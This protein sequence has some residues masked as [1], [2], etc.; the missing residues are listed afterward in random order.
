MLCALCFVDDSDVALWRF[1]CAWYVAGGQ[2]WAGVSVDEGFF[3]EGLVNYWL[4]VGGVH[5]AAGPLLWAMVLYGHLVAVVVVRMLCM[6]IC[7]S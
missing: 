1:S 2:L 7:P 5:G 6:H 4:L 3:F